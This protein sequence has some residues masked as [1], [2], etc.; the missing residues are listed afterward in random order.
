MRQLLARLVIVAGAVWASAAWGQG[1]VILEWYGHGFVR[2]TSSQGVRVAMD[3]F[4]EIGY[5]M[6]RVAADIVTVSHEHGDHNNARLIEGNPVV[7]RGLTEGGRDWKPI[8]YRLK[9]V[10]LSSIPVYHD[11]QQGALRGKNTIVTLDI[12]SLRVAHLSDMGHVPTEA[13]LQALGRVDVVL[14][15][16]GGKFSIDGR[17]A[18]QVLERLNPRVAIP[19]HYKTPATATWSIE[20]E[21]GFVEGYPRVKRLSGWRVFLVPGALPAATEIWVLEPPRGQ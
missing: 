10:S 14:L 11:D 19:I 2:L 18:R 3:P 17:Q 4:G 8:S 13:Q 20:D 12:G 16:V 6:P 15:P 1:V 7:L 5:P 21:R 9:D